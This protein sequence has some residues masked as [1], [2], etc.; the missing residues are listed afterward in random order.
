M[1]AQTVVSVGPYELR[2][3]RPADQRST[4]SGGQVSAATTS[5]I[6][7]GSAPSG[8]S[9]STAGVIAAWVTRWRT[10]SSARAGPGTVPGSATTR[11]EPVSRPIASSQ[12]PPSKA[13]DRWC[14]T[15]LPGTTPSCEV[16][17]SSRP[18]SPVCVTVTPLGR[19]VVPE[20]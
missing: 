6:A 10:A 20:V 12:N 4:S 9:W 17:M 8:I 2:I 19:P 11:V 14:R 7:A 15:R 3:R 1:V 5:V 13:G 18:G 16:K